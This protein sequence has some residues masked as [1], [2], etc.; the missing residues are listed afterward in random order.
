MPYLAVEHVESREFEL[1]TN[2]VRTRLYRVFYTEDEEEAR[3][4]ILDE[5]P[6]SDHNLMRAGCRAKH[7]G[8]GVWE[9]EVRYARW[10]EQNQRTFSTLG[11]TQRVTQ[12][13][14]TINSYAPPGF[15][16]PN[17]QGAIG[18]SED[19]VEGVDIPV[20]AMEFTEVHYFTPLQMTNTFI[21][22][23]YQMTP[24][25]NLSAFR[26]CNAGEC[27]FRGVSGGQ[28]GDE[29]WELT[30]YFAM[31]PNATGLTIGDITGID[32]LGHDYLWVRYG[33]YVDMDSYQLV[34]R[35]L[36]VHVERVIEGGDF[37]NLGI[38]VP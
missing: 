38:P 3:F 13:L 10:E 15:T 9:G 2:P 7:L 26:M 19:R 24:R 22:T 8:G 14:S 21:R 1:G 12:S 31:S 37:T 16:P 18:V 33:D 28:R 30:F 35:P 32:K 36:S 5:A 29:N 17:F 23:L 27:L 11:G 6:T 20:P 25:W 34:K 4:A